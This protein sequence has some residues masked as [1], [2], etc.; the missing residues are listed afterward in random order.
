MRPWRRKGLMENSAVAMP[1]KG[2]STMSKAALIKALRD[3]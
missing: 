1:A 2:R 3:H